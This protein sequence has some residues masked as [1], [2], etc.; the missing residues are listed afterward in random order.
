LQPF[1]FFKS[2]G[3]LNLD[4][5]LDLGAA[6]FRW[7]NVTE[8]GRFY[9]GSQEHWIGALLGKVPLMPTAEIALTTMLISEG[10]Y[11]SEA[12]GREVTAEE[13]MHH[14]RPAGVTNA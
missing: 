1:G 12:L 11:L 6:K 13:I 7:D 3:H 10:I 8:I 14:S 4:A 2:Y 5:G 9:A